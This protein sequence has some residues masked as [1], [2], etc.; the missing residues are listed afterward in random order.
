MIEAVPNRKNPESE[1]CGG[2]Y[3]NCWIKA[4]TSIKAIEIEEPY[5]IF[6]F[7]KPKNISYKQNRDFFRIPAVFDCIYKIA[8]KDGIKEYK[9]KYFFAKTIENHFQLCY[10]YGCN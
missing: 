2:A 3:I 9:T 5:V 1:E 6:I 10:N 7:E 4:E 8:G